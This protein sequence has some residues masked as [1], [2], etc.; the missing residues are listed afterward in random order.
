MQFAAMFYPLLAVLIWAMNAV[1]NKLST[2]VVEPETISFYRWFFAFLILTP[3]CLKKSIKEWQTIKPYLAKLAFLGLLGM[4]LYQCLAY[5][6]AYTISA[7]MIG[8]FI[9]LIPLLTIIL[10][11]FILKTPITLGLIIGSALSF[12]G[13]IWLISGGM[14]GI[15]FEVGVGQGE[16]MMLVAASAYALY[17]VLTKKWQIRLSVW[18]S[19]YWQ[20]IFGMIILLPLFWLA[21]DRAIT[22]D[23]IGL[24]LFAGI[25]ASI[26]APFLWIKGVAFLG[27]NK[28]ALFMNLSPLL[29][30]LISIVVLHESLESYHY[31]GGA[32]SLT[33]VMIAQRFSQ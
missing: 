5:Y 28:T 11:L 31:I 32:V 26:I 4:A 1:V 21:A 30:A 10:S 19:L 13:I 12:F 17:G 7:T 18:Q 8:I 6:A 33:G 20:I 24:I 9:S 16:L 23:N 25:P 27:P 15:L 29:T 3:F 14:P 22:I 2:G